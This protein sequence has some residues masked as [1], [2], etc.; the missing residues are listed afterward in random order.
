[1]STSLTINMSREHVLERLRANLALAEQLD[2]EALKAHRKGEAEALKTIK[3]AMR[4]ALKWDWPTMKAK[5]STRYYGERSVT[6]TLPTGMLPPQCPL[7]E[8][9]KF[10]NAIRLLEIDARKTLKLS[11]NSDFGRL[12]A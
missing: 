10:A 11:V 8:A 7:L 5:T 6:V 12:V 1:M 3:A 4:E 9:P 2:A